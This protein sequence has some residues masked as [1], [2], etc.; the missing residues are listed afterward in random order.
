MVLKLLPKAKYHHLVKQRKL[1]D[2]KL[3]KELHENEGWSI[4][5]MCK[6]LHIS[7]AAYYQWTH[8]KPS[9]KDREDERIVEAIKEVS[10]SNNSLFGVMKM[11]YVLKNKYHFTCGHNR[12]Y[13]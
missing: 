8:H 1:E 13:R 12:V 3:I 9:N 2:Y 10:E 5:F 7:R 11:Y 6:E 4:E